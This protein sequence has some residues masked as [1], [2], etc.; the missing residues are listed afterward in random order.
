MCLKMWT[1]TKK[2]ISI[3]GICIDFISRKLHQWRSRFQNQVWML[4]IKVLLPFI[5]WYD[6]KIQVII[7][8]SPQWESL[9]LRN[10]FQACSEHCSILLTAHPAGHRSI[11]FC[12]NIYMLYIMGIRTV[13]SFSN[14]ANL[15]K[16]CSWQCHQSHLLCDQMNSN[17]F[18]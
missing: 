8:F 18:I 17:A 1:Q 3:Y 13:R 11:S 2:N 16:I 9:L 7:F 14:L 4:P 12:A 5:L 10:S 15:C 6:L